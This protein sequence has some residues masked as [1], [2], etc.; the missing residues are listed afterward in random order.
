[1]HHV[2]APIAG[3]RNWGALVSHCYLF[4]NFC[5]AASSSYAVDHRRAGRVR[6]VMFRFDMPAAEFDFAHIY[7]GRGVGRDDDEGGRR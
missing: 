2:S 4:C 6:D 3:P 7:G 5:S 1:M